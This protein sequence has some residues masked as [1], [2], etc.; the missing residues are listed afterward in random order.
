VVHQLYYPGADRASQRFDDDYAGIRWTSD[1]EKGC[2]HT[3]ETW[4]WP[5][6]GGGKTAPTLTAKPSFSHQT[7][8]WRQHFPANMSVRA[9][10][11]DKGGVETNKDKVIQ[12]EIVGT[13]DDTKGGAHDRWLAAGIPHL[14][15]PE[16]PEWFLDKFADFC[17]WAHEEWGV[18]LQ[19]PDLWLNYGPDS[20]TPGRVPASYGDTPARMSGSEF[21]AFRG[22]LGHMHAT[23]NDHG[24]PGR[25]NMPRV[26][27]LARRKLAPV[28]PATTEEINMFIGTHT[29]RFFLVDGN[30]KRILSAAAA[31]ELVKSLGIKQVA[32]TSATLTEFPTYVEDGTIGGST[33]AKLDAADDIPPASPEA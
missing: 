24:D 14:F 6:Y 26:M 32:L 7:I 30:G 25:F 28:K 20:R 22:W 27:T 11:N 12:V 10:Q 29:G 33:V 3:T 18:R 1:A 16:A 8:Q 31:A 5:G 21:N 17:A 15:T 4:N 9:L 23:E 2:V 19:C 13:C